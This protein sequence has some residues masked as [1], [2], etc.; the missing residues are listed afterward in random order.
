[1][2]EVLVEGDIKSFFTPFP[3]LETPRLILRALRPNDLDDLYAYASDPEID[4][5]T[6]WDHCQ[7]RDETQT[8]LAGY[9]AAYDQDG[10]DAWGIELREA[11]ED[12]RLIG[13]C[14]FVYWRPRNRRAEIGYTIARAYWGHGYAT[15]A[16][17]TMID[18]GFERMP[19]A[20]TRCGR[21]SRRTC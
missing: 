21:A 9:L 4:H 17:R 7:S 1:M 14:N 12:R 5:Y 19:K 11:R 10:L 2:I 13:T 16:A 3:T 8:D 15:E 6:P 20:V 18:F